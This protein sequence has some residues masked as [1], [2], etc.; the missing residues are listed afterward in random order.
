MPGV[1]ATWAPWFPDFSSSSLTAATV[2]GVVASPATSSTPGMNGSG[3]G[4]VHGE[5]ALGVLHGADQLLDRDGRGV[6]ADD[7]VGAGVLG[8]RAEHVALDVEALEDGLL[9]EV[10]VGDGLLDRLA[11]G[12]VL[13]DELGRAR[14]EQPL[15]LEL[16]RL[17]LQRSREAFALST[18][19]SAMVTSKPA[20][21]R[22][23]AMPPPM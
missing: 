3:V 8:D 9:D 11:G 7:R 5:E 21:A 18:L 13:R 23:W 16:A 15:L 4:E 14:G 6:G 12:D 10:D 1:S 17:A 22:T 20:M 19:T 2:S